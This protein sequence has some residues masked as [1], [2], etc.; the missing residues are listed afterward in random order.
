MTY[1]V[2]EFCLGCKYGD[3]IDVCPAD[4]F[5]EGPEMVY[6]NPETC[7]DCDACVEQC[8]VKA[9]YEG[10]D[11]P[12]IWM[13]YIGKN[14]KASK[15]YPVITEKCDPLPSAKTYEELTRDKNIKIQEPKFLDRPWDI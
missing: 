10:E 6:I 4:A 13:E 9:I 5:H 14:A 15:I 12:E 11:L 2:T 8:P 3:C 1:I 7:T